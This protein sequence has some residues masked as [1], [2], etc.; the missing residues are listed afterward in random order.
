MRSYL[1]W[2]V[3]TSILFSVINFERVSDFDL[4]IPSIFNWHMR[5]VGPICLVSWCWEPPLQFSM[6]SVSCCQPREHD[7]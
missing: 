7:S 6:L 3:E 1:A 4:Q 5:R 2:K